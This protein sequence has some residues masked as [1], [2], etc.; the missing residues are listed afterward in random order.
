MINGA[1]AY[2]QV[3]FAYHTPLAFEL[4]LVLSIKT[5]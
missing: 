5:E 1:R 4:S 3:E 2:Q